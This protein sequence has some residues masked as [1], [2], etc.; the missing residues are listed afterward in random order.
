MKLLSCSPLHPV[1][2][3]VARTPM[4]RAAN[5]LGSTRC[6]LRRTVDIVGQRRSGRRRTDSCFM[7]GL[8]GAGSGVSP[9]GEQASSGSEGLVRSGVRGRIGGVGRAYAAKPTGTAARPPGFEHRQ[10]RNVPHAGARAQ[11]KRMIKPFHV[12]FSP[13]TKSPGIRSSKF[14]R[15]GRRHLRRSLPVASAAG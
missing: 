7:R 10:E 11:Y 9:A 14:S 5:Q 15:G 3:A 4:K 1:R 12:R 8:A 13:R 6:V 2:T